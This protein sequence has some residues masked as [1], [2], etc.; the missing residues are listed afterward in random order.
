[1]SGYDGWRAGNRWKNGIALDEDTILAEGLESVHIYGL[2]SLHIYCC[3][4][5]PDCTAQIWL[6]AQIYT[7]LWPTVF[8]QVYRL[9]RVIGP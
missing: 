4:Q 8:L 1:M 3:I 2:E 7:T 6:A 5:V 9:A